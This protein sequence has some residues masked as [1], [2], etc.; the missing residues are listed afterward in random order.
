MHLNK[1]HLLL[2]LFF[3]GFCSLQSFHVKINQKSNSTSL[4]HLKVTS[5]SLNFDQQLKVFESLGYK[6][7]DGITKKIIFS[8]I[9]KNDQTIKDPESI[10][11]ESEFEKVYCYLGWFYFDNAVK[12]YTDNCIWYD[13]EFIDPSSEYITFMERMGTITNKELIFSEISIRVDKSDYE[14]I[15]F[16][17]NGISK[18]WKLEKVGYVDDSFFQRFSYLPGEFKTKGKYTYYSD[19]GQQF[20]IDYAT[21]DEQREFIKKTKLKREW[22]G[23]GNH[24]SEHDP[25]K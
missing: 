20:V 3:F 16:K 8:E 4:S 13:L 2:L 25:R 19:G 18:K 21:E 17:V 12:Y 22:L 15:D 10:F 1:K 14:W 9:R 7:N 5:D 11:K 23:E 6:L 24:F